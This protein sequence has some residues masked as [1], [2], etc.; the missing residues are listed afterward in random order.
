M[1][2]LATLSHPFYKICMEL[3]GEINEAGREGNGDKIKEGRKKGRKEG[4]SRGELET[5]AASGKNF[6][7]P[8]LDVLTLHRR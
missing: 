4:S 3:G 8:T 1:D 6:H 7:W 5:R 2:V